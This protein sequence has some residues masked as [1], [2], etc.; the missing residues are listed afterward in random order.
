M[1]GRKKKTVEYVAVKSV[2]KFRRRK[3]LNEV[4]C[5]LVT[6]TIFLIL[7]DCWFKFVLEHSPDSCCIGANLSQSEEQTYP[8]I[9]QLV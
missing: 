1:Q 3:V 2:E 5:L 8:Q 6:K 9:L 7:S 4:S